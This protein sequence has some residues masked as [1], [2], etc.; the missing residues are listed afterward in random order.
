MV[1]QVPDPASHTAEAM[2]FLQGVVGLLPVTPLFLQSSVLQKAMVSAQIHHLWR[3]DLTGS[4]LAYF[5]FSFL[6]LPT[7]C[8]L[9]PSL[10]NL[11]TGCKELQMLRGS[12]SSHSYA[13]LK[14]NFLWDI[15]NN[16]KS[17]Q[18]L[19]VLTSILELCYQNHPS[20]MSAQTEL[21]ISWDW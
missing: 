8:V 12:V 18:R 16:K 1:L 10:L 19:Y 20:Y 4:V 9:A 2:I 3:S 21:C 7:S 17:P 14:M 15:P 6:L 13:T 11:H 5:F